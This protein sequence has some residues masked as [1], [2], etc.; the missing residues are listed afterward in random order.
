MYLPS[1][2]AYGSS[3]LL[4]SGL[5]PG[6]SG[7]SVINRKYEVRLLDRNARSVS[8]RSNYLLVSIGLHHFIGGREA[9]VGD[10]MDKQR[11]S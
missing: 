4:L 11:Q 6:E 3:A 5:L 1:I 2:L 10:G 9:V 7:G 8:L